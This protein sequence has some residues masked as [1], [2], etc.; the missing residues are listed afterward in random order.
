MKTIVKKI[1]WTILTGVMVTGCIG[2]RDFD[3]VYDIDSEGIPQFIYHDFT[4][5]EKISEISMFRS[6]YGHDYS[7]E[8]E[9][10]R[11]MK[12]YYAP[13]SEYA[14]NNEIEIYS[15]VNGKIH[16]I[17]NEGH[18]ESNGLENKQIRIVPE[19]YPAF[20]VIIFHTDLVSSDIVS[21]KTV[22]A[23]ELIGHA[24]MVYPDIPETAHDFDIAVSVNT[25]QGRKLLSFFDTMTDTVFNS[26]MARGVLER[27]NLIIS[28][29][30]RD[31]DALTCDEHHHFL[32]SGS[33]I[34]WWEF[35]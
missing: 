13:Y 29:E 31:V 17:E 28:K 34:N 20:K 6:G 23:G 22:Y 9:S 1:F 2:D 10:C 16:S 11:S 18:G 25:P 27:S 32:T 19:G 12:H 3:A 4:Q 26:Y 21:G 14:N 15:P 8:F 7:D 33:L 24:R 5:L 30:D 35:D